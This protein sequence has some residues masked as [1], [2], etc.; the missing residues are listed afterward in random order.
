MNVQCL[1]QKAYCLTSKHNLL[2]RVEFLVVDEDASQSP[3]LYKERRPGDVVYK[4]LAPLFGQVN[5]DPKSN[6]YH[7][8][9]QQVVADVAVTFF[10][11]PVGF[12]FAEEQKMRIRSKV[13]E[14]TGIRPLAA[15]TDP[16]DGSEQ[17]A[18]WVLSGKRFG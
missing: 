6:P 17:Q 3:N 7:P 16:T 14:V 4:T 18:G 2:T 12:S 8:T 11:D 15:H 13:Y 9:G 5:F 10:Q 1:Q